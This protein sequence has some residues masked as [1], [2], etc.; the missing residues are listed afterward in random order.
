MSLHRTLSTDDASIHTLTFHRKYLVLLT[1][2]PPRLESYQQYFGELGY[3][4]FFFML[5][6]LCHAKHKQTSKSQYIFRY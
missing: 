3:N 1:E 2:K 5:S 4:Q 6:G